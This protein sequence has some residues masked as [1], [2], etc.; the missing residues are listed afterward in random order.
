M[1]AKSISGDGGNTNVEEETR[2]ITILKIDKTGT[3]QV[4]LVEQELFTLS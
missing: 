1:S 3:G 4:P 2:S